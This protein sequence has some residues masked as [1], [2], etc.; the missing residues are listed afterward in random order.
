[1]ETVKNLEDGWYIL[2]DVHDTGEELGLYTD[3][4]DFTEMGP[5]I[6]EWERLSELKHLQLLFA[7]QPYFGRELRYFNQAP[8]WYR[9]EFDLPEGKQ[10]RVRLQFTNVDYYCKVWVNGLPAGEHEGYSAP[11]SF[12]ITD[13]VRPGAKNLLIV[14]VSSPWDEEVEKGKEDSRTILV[15]RR[16]VKGTYEHSDTFIQRDVNPV[17][18]YGRVELIITQQESMEARPEISYELSEGMDSAVV[19][20]KVVLGGLVPGAYRMVLKIK[21]ERTGIHKAEAAL[22]FT[23]EG[24]QEERVCSVKMEDFLLWNTWDHGQPRMY[25]A[26]VLLERDGGRVCGKETVFAFRK[27]EI[28]RTGEM[29][30]FR[31]NGRDFFVRGTSYFPDCY[32]SAMTE[33][34]YYRDLLNIKAA[35]FNLVR[36]HVHVEQDIFYDLCDKMG[37]AVIQDSEYNWTHPSTDAWAEKFIGIYKENVRMLMRHPSIICWIGMNEPG[38]VDPDG[39]TRRRFM[40]ESPG[41]R[42]YRELQEMD[43]DRPIIKGSFCNEDIFSG[44]SHNYLGSLSGG[45][46]REIYGTTEKLNTEYGFDAP[47]CAESLKKVPVVYGRLAGIE[48]E[49]P[50]IQDYQYKLLKYY[51]EHYRI[52]KY[53]PCSGYVQFMFIDLCPQSFYGLYDWW[54]IPK[55]GLQAMLE[56]NSPVGIFAKYRDSLDGIYAV[57]DTDKKYEGCEVSWVI[58]ESKGGDMVEQGTKKIHMEPDSVK[59]AV[60]FKDGYGERKRW[61]LYVSITGKDGSCI[62]QNSYRD[63]FALSSRVKGHP[64]RMSHETGMRIYW[65]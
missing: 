30:R 64:E 47:A 54:G 36:V 24:G 10:Q 20:A 14:K 42:L 13:L 44:D 38:C 65:A 57:N 25:T 16:M 46:Y 3:R 56:S 53:A 1:M 32:I 2:Q 27:T 26:E 19:K 5:Q 18:I 37:M 12:D 23:A 62:A 11:F 34:R 9:Y 21:D 4:G 28:M 40:E 35:G 43:A 8:W 15:K 61:D 58:T 55:K 49:I 63:I 59:E 29:T 33:E 17:G 22:D 60:H 51:T 52:Q 39:D 7:D 45:Q 31:L 48:K 50:A 6:S 41:P